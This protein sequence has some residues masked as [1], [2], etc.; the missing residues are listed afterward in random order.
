[1]VTLTPLVGHF[2]AGATVTEHDELS[3]VPARLG[4]PVWGPS[5]LLGNLELY[6]GLPTPNV[7]DAVRV[8]RWSRRLDD[9]HASRRRFY[10]DSYVVDPLGTATALL[11]MRDE[12][13]AA[14][15]NGES[16]AAGGE[17]LETF[18]E[19]EAGADL[20]PGTVDRLRRVE[21]ELRRARLRPFEELRLAERRTVWPARWQRVF[22]LLEERG[23]PVR[24]APVTFDSGARDTDVARVQAF[25]RG[26]RPSSPAL[27]GDGS[28]VVLRAETSWELADALAA[29]LRG[30]NEPSTAILRGGEVH[31]LDEALR[32]QG[33]PSQGVLSVNRW[34]PAAQVLPLA[35][36]LAFEPRDPYRV[37]EL[38]TL[39]VGPFEGIAGRELASALSEAPGIGGPPWQRAKVAIAER[40]KEGAEDRLARIA[41]WLEAPGHETVAPRLALLAVADRVRIWLQGRLAFERTKDASSPRCEALG[42]AFAQAQAFHAALSFDPREELDLVAA[43]LLVEQVS[44]G[45]VAFDRS[46]EQ[47]GRID[48]V[49]SPSGLRLARDVV[50]WW[51]CVSGTEGRPS[52]RPWRLG[53]VSALRA[54]GVV[55]PDPAERLTAEGEAWRQVVLA[56]RER[57]VLAMPRWSKGEPLEPHPIWDEIVAGLGA[58]DADTAWLTFEARTL[59]E[60][61]K[62]PH[63]AEAVNL[64]ALA[65]PEARPEWTLDGAKLTP[66]RSHS[67]SSLEA[68][69]GCPLRWVLTYRAGIR[70]GALASIPSGPRLNGTLG[71]RLVEGLHLAGA[72]ERPAELQYHIEAHLDR[73]LREEGAVLL[74]AG[75]TFELAQ[76]RKQF[77]SSIARLAVLLDESGLTVVD[78][79]STVEVPWRTGALTGRFDLIL[80][81]A[82]GRE[83]ILDL[84][85]GR[86]RYEDLLARGHAI[87]LAVYSAAR[88]I[89]SGV[90]AM[91]PAAYFSLN[92]GEL[93]VLDDGP[94]ARARPIDGPS[95]NETWAKVER[96]VGQVEHSL[97]N[98]R[99]VVTGVR[100][101]RPLLEALGVPDTH[102]SHHHEPVREA[103][104]GYCPHGALC[105]RNWERLA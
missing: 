57:L 71:H 6:L 58:S 1:M 21:D 47:A 81:D 95:L 10:S 15:W 31:A 102:R 24:T 45:G 55:L 88:R 53:E 103:A 101:S 85:W 83:A 82:Q 26:E 50:V 30:W 72:L 56:A 97:T 77:A 105:G 64:G 36:E 11:A 32:A 3:A 22:A 23:V 98:G 90:S 73:L 28:L 44:K 9:A 7:T 54:A 68:L 35:V 49:D 99:A 86:R 48:P 91:P 69:A 62:G 40:M 12:L 27:R 67:A 60:G 89:Q 74:R 14:G 59:L 87:Q 18:C 75:M 25:V 19:L 78:V 84:K 51:H 76:L 93:I 33:L 34:R 65:L 104:C 20:P 52:P 46:V 16:I 42:A 29:L 80:A 37:L 100:R 43:R 39:P 79:E 17:R 2:F 94:F 70:P 41:E 61:R 92:S 38:L 66:A 4:Q 5:A 8:Q 96:T 63:T 13:V